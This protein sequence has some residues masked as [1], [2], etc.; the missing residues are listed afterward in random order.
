[1]CHG[2]DVGNEVGDQLGLRLHVPEE[3]LLSH[4]ER[5]CFFVDLLQD[6][7]AAPLSLLGRVDWCGIGCNSSQLAPEPVFQACLLYTSDAADE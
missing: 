1:M 6:R 3:V 2:F 5:L 7:D 4:P